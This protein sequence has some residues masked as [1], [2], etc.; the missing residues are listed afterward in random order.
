MRVATRFL[1]VITAAALT[2][3]VGAAVAPATAAPAGM[4]TATAVK[5]TVTITKLANKKV[6]YGKKATYKPAVKTTGKIKVTSK[7]L[8][9]KQ[10][11]KTLYKN[12]SSVA[13]KA[14]TY[15][16]TS[17]VKYKVGTVKAGSATVVYGAT[18]T[19]TLTQTI[20]VTQGAKPNWVWGTGGYNCP[21]GYP[22]KGN[23]SG[24]YHVK[25]GAYYSRTK[26]E[27]CFT[28]AAAAKAA[29]YRASKR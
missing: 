10:G 17:T 1:S 24:I 14:G 6:A 27:Q 5:N 12:K 28:T 25:G 16:I 19:K 11:T 29:G 4:A 22:V 3:G 9:V 15:K 2:F 26:P 8:T 18:K 20:K 13:L 21:A 7:T 23:Q